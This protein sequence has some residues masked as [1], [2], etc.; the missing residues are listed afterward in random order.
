MSKKLHWFA[1]PCSIENTEQ[2]ETLTVELQR[3]GVGTL[4]GGIFKMRTRPE[5]FQGLREEGIELIKA[6]KLKNDFRFISEVSTPE[7]VELLAPI[8]DIFQIGSRSMYSYELLKSV[9]SRPQPIFLKRAF[10]AT[11]EEWL[12]AA[13]YCRSHNSD[14]EIWMCERGVR[15]FDDVFRN[16]LDVNAI[17]Y[18]AQKTPY[19][20]VVDASH[21]TGK[22]EFVESGT[23][24]GIAAG[25]EG[26]MLEVHP[27]PSKAMSDAEQAIDLA[28]FETIKLKADALFAHMKA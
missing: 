6:A 24:A 14:K 28:K 13:D 26:V 15:G 19:K 5:S 2:W 21:A 12:G 1:G 16:T 11:L 8:V 17:A 7:Q 3:L 10:S 18:I 25:A 4:R 22:A 9:A 27:N 20:A 23:L